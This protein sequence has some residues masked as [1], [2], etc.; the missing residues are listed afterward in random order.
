M[1]ETERTDCVFDMRLILMLWKQVCESEFSLVNA[2]ETETQTSLSVCLQKFLT[3]CV[4]LPFY[5]VHAH[6]CLCTCL[7]A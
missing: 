1:R 4:K 5:T 2:C 3:T 7:S 6:A